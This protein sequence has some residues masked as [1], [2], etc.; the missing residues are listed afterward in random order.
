MSDV[1][2]AAASDPPHVRSSRGS[3]G[4][5]VVGVVWSVGHGL[6]L[7]GPIEGS[8]FVVFGIAALVATVLGLR[9]GH[10]A[11]RWPWWLICSALVLFVVGGA[12]RQADQQVGNLTSSRPLLPDL[13]TM[14]GYLL[15]GLG[16]AGLANVHRL[17]RPDDLDSIL[18]ALVA[19][20][21][22]LTL[23]WVFLIDPAL[24]HQRSPLS[25]R[26]LL[27][28]YP[29]M[30]VFIVAIT[31]RIAL[32]PRKRGA[33]AYRYL[34]AAMMLLVSGDVIYMLIEIG[35]IAIPASLV[36]VPYALAFVGLG[37][38]VL[39]P[40]MGELCHGAAAGEPA[41]R[42][43]RLFFVAVALAIPALVTVTRRASAAGDRLVLS[44]IILGLTGMGIWRVLRAIR[45]NARSEARLSHQATH[46]LLTGLPNRLAARDYVVGALAKAACND[47]RV[48]LVFLDV[49]RFK[50]VNDTLGHSGGDELLVAVGER[51][52]EYVRPTDL[53]ARIGGDE[54]VV[55]REDVKELAQAVLFAERIRDCFEIPFA[56]GGSEIYS[57][58]SLGVA[59]ADG[60]DPLVDAEGMIRDAD[61][62][63]YQAKDSGRNAVA[64]FDM[65]MRDRVTERLALDQQLRHALERGE[66]H[67]HFQPII[68]RPEN[69][70]EGFEALVRW[71]HPVLGEVPPAKFIPIAEDSGL[72][73]QIGAWVLEEACRALA[74]WR[75]DV[76]G[77]ANLHVAVNISACQLRNGALLGTVEAALRDNGLPGRALCLELT[78]SLL[79]DHAVNAVSL[80]E[81]LRNLQVAISIDDFGTGYSS[82]AYLKRFPVDWVKIDQ[83][84]VA[85][86]DR[87]DTSDESL[88]AAIIAM[89]AAL[90]MTTIA[91]GVETVGQ[92]TR[93][94]GLGCNLIQGYLHSHPVPPDQVPALLRR[95][96][97]PVRSLRQ[98][99]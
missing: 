91:E 78:E 11:L 35:R 2:V 97:R 57:T 63:M 52:S 20:L 28:G 88:V 8:T 33:V 42:R 21:A 70:I 85:G 86:L 68:R 14:P 82:L 43:G 72:I 6:N 22:A 89:A 61:T 32:S 19:A 37:A 94:T 46:D 69:R 56:I 84:F 47:S 98:T 53:V 10:P 62:A 4:F 59:T 79:I 64:V 15:L 49:D 51:L 26:L 25:V 31:A 55:V 30:S 76:P 95:F 38:S 58:A 3:L 12:V 74:T 60:S 77:A 9:W 36:D 54:F 92:Q 29:A 81:A 93:L 87:P 7:L 27:A 5:A 45:A 71:T 50:L 18:D 96:N 48:A 73:V 44:A 75:N 80:L 34:L 39:H 40:S 65:T 83:S 23:A 90:G 66:L 13:I 17:A 99:A 67:L 24:F 16:L 41:R 1:L